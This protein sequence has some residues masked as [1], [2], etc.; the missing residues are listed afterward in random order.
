[1][2]HRINANAF[3]YQ[4][5]DQQDSPRF[6]FLNLFPARVLIFFSFRTAVLPNVYSHVL[7]VLQLRSIPMKC[8]FIE[9]HNPCTIS[10]PHFAAQNMGMGFVFASHVML[11]T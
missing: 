4:N 1:M 6:T 8:S 2:K 5:K 10:D 7:S 11:R 9:R 3:I